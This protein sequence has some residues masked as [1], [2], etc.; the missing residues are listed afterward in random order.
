MIT[1]NKLEILN[2][3][4][5]NIFLKI[6]ILQLAKVLKKKSYAKIYDAV[7]D[8]ERDNIVKSEK[9]GNSNII[10]IY[11]TSE[12]VLEL[13]YLDEQESLSKKI[14]NIEKILDFKEF[15]DDIILVTGSYA[16]DKQTSKSD[17]DLVIITKED[18]FK[19]QKLID[20]TTSLLLP[21]IHP[22]VIS[23]K[24]FIEMLLDSQENYGK[25]IFKNRLLFRNSRR[26]YEL[27]KE[28]IKN[29]F[30]G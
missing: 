29:G 17:I 30:R 4:R 24:D 8:L 11:L 18:P 12:S 26:Y 19:K 6:S 16:N 21:K 9:I 3:F 13:S 27:I 14:P 10:S 25:E 2:L 28:A 23:Y 20:N 15:L 22:I 5:K 1:K 7:K